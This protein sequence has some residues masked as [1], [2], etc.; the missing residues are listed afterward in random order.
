[1]SKI[2]G[3][4]TKPNVYP[5]VRTFTAG[6]TWNR[7]YVFQIQTG[8]A[9]VG[10]TY[11]NNGVTYTVY[12]TVSSANQVIMNGSGAPTSSGTL[13]KTGGSG[14]ATLTFSTVFAP[15]SVSIRM[16]G[17]GGG[18]GGAGAPSPTNGGG[19]G[20]TTFNGGTAGGGGGGATGGSGGVGGSA[21]AITS[22]ILSVTIRGND[23]NPSGANVSG[24]GSGGNGGASTWP[25]GAGKGGF[26]SASGTNAD[27]NCGSGGGGGATT[28]GSGGGGGA[29]GGFVSGILLSPTATYSM[30]I[31]AAGSGGTGG[32]GGGTGSGG[33]IE[34]T[35]YFA[36]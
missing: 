16:H 15:I 11:T 23:G 24:G 25:G 6:T 35:E 28:G 31:G 13:T 12:A 26:G 33:I 22:S 20:N 29:A 5:V 14:D 27:N 3:L 8:S 21:S 7:S 30:A 2:V 10:A 19:G 18:G 32:S 17:G 4:H 36:T 9:T 1:M 34:T